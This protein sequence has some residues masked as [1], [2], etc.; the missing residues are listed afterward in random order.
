MSVFNNEHPINIFENRLPYMHHQL[1]VKA[2]YAMMP[3]ITLDEFQEKSCI[4]SQRVSKQTLQYMLANG[5]GHESRNIYTFSDSDRIKLAIL[6]IKN[7]VDIES[8]SKILNWRDFEAFASEILGLSGYDTERNVRF[9]KPRRVEIDVVATNKSAKRA[10]LID[11][12]HWH[13]NDLKSISKYAVKQIQ[14]ASILMSNRK[15]VTSS[16]PL[17][18]T[19]YPVIPKIVEEIPIVSIRDFGSFLDVMPL[20]LDKI[21]IISK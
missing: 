19:L 11:C 13:R 21:K 17:I 8:I 15:E 20:Y 14:R 12:K 2:M 10:V 6:G 18:L 9:N 3:V 16:I 7:G 4:A 1:L 5:I